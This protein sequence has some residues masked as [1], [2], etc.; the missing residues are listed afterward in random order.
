MVIT[1]NR[2]YCK[3]RL[4]NKLLHGNQ[5]VSKGIKESINKSVCHGTV[6]DIHLQIARELQPPGAVEN[7]N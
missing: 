6:T 2:I 4:Q 1:I 3:F 5:Q 7:R